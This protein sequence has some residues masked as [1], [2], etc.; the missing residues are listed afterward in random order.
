MNTISQLLRSLLFLFFTLAGLAI[1][2]VFLVIAVFTMAIMYVFYL[3]RGKKF[4]AANYWQQSR[5]KVK[6]RH[7]Q[8]SQHF[9]QP[10]YSRRKEQEVS[11][12]EVR[13]IK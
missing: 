12:A 2:F 3:I 4:S 5:H 8:F 10:S 6:Q 7:S 9:R 13:E 11:D 1:A